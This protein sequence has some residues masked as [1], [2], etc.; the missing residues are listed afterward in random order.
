MANRR[1]S[2]EPWSPCGCRRRRSG[3]LLPSGCPRRSCSEHRGNLIPRPDKR[4]K[5]HLHASGLFGPPHED[6][7]VDVSAVGFEE[8]TAFLVTLTKHVELALDPRQL[9]GNVLTLPA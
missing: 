3:W 2:I 9:S 8:R 5:T 4:S 7:L 6:E 1:I